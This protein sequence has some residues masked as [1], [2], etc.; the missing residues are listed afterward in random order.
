M[1]A[2]ETAGALFFFQMARLD[3]HNDIMEYVFSYLSYLHMLFQFSLVKIKQILDI[4]GTIYI[5]TL[6]STVQDNNDFVL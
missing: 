2:Y 5:H 6:Y 4:N 1:R 3:T